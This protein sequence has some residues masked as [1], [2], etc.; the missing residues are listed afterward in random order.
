M[1]IRAANGRTEQFAHKC[2]TVVVSLYSLAFGQNK[3]INMDIKE[4]SNFNT[5][6]T[7]IGNICN[8]AFQEVPF[9]SKVC[10]HINVKISS[11]VLGGTRPFL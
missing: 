2:E 5:E 4:R 7:N 1:G 6:S 8:E 10:Q 9:L 3:L 11:I